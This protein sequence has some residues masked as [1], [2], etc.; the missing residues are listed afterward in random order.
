MV[1]CWQEIV[2][3]AQADAPTIRPRQY[4]KRQQERLHARAQPT[5]MELARVNPM[6][7]SVARVP[8]CRFYAPFHASQAILAVCLAGHI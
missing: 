3:V 7:P 1:M 4:A 6:L 8:N 5:A 2:M